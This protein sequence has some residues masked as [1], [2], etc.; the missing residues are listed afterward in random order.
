MNHTK[1]SHVLCL[2]LVQKHFHV[3][4]RP[5]ILLYPYIYPCQLTLGETLLFYQYIKSVFNNNCLPTAL[6]NTKDS[7]EF[8]EIISKSLL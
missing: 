3:Q 7:F 5:N 1:T 6:M 8:H 2:H 4:W